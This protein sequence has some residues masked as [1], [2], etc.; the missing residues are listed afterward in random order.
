LEDFTGFSDD[1]EAFI[2]LDISNIE[3]F[4]TREYFIRKIKGIISGDITKIGF[5]EI[6]NKK[7]F[8]FEDNV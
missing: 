3:D 2:F 1:N 4:I 7:L 8:F 5:V 6:D